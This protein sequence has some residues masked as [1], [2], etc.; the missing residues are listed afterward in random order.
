MYVC[1]DCETELRIEDYLVSGFLQLNNE[2]DLFSGTFIS[3]NTVTRSS[4]ASW[5]CLGTVPVVRYCTADWHGTRYCTRNST[6][7]T[8]YYQAEE[9]VGE[10]GTTVQPHLEPICLCCAASIQYII[11]KL[12]Y[13]IS[14][15][16][17]RH[18][19]HSCLMTSLYTYCLL[20]TVHSKTLAG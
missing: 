15:H 8:R 2:I 1:N 3:S 14:Y 10:I 18:F 11:K 19:F 20:K 16:D 13:E 9:R 6:V 5:L 12:V 7:R 17:V 4:F